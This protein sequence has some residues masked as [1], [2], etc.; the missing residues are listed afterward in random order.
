VSYTPQEIGELAQWRYM[1]MNKYRATWDILSAIYAGRHSDLFPDEF[2]AGDVAKIAGFIRHA[3]NVKKGY[4]AAVPNVYV[5][6]LKETAAGHAVQD[7]LEKIIA[8]YHSAWVMKARMNPFALFEVL[9][10][11]VALGCVP[12]PRSKMP[13]MLVEDPRN[14]LPGAGWT[15]TTTTGQGF[16]GF[17][18]NSWEAQTDMGAGGCEDMIIRKSM[19]GRQIMDTWGAGDP[20]LALIVGKSTLA[21]RENWNILQWYDAR[22]WQT[23]LG[24]HNVMLGDCEHGAPWCPWWFP[25]NFSPDTAAGDSDFYQQIGLEV[26]YLRILAQKLALNDAVIWPWVWQKGIWDVNPATRFMQASS[27]DAAV[28]T[29]SPPPEMQVDRDLAMLMTNLRILNGETQATQGT[30]PGGPITGQGITALNQ[31]PVA[32]DVQEY[33]A[34]NGPVLGRLYGTALIQD[35]TC[36]P[37][38]RKTLGAWARGE[39]FMVEYTPGKDIPTAIGAITP[40]FGPGL[41]GYQGHIQLL[42]DLGAD[43]VSKRSVMEQNPSIRSVRS[44]LSRLQQEKIEGMQF[45][46]MTGQVAVPMDWLAAAHKAVGEGTDLNEWI[47]ANPPGQAGA[48][49]ANT[50]PVPPGVAAAQ[51]ASAQAAPGGGGPPGGPAPAPGPLGG[52]EAPAPPGLASPVGG[53]GPGPNVWHPPSLSRLVGS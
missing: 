34:R 32:Q 14:A 15:G 1:Q 39:T 36:F 11:A 18:V 40:N 35:R 12:D 6:P 51:A 47:F 24:G 19:T 41:G 33:F 9:F 10:G 5:T 52:M 2:P 13:Q 38:E 8:A 7:T 46:A 23:V 16:L 17:N 28:G 43:A 3:V 45:A 29:L 25:T 21:L 42:Q 22:R 50:P 53:V 27:P 30:M 49:P 20:A 37:L 48:T 31:T 44:E 4:V 26:G